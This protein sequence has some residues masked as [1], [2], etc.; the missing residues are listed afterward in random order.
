LVKISWDF[1][2]RKVGWAGSQIATPQVGNHIFRMIGA[3]SM[4]RA[5]HERF[6]AHEVHELHGMIM[7]RA[8]CM[9]TLFNQ[10]SPFRLFGVFRG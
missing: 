7:G 2:G 8:L 1:T 10:T 5:N 4:K 6:E 9:N 3:K